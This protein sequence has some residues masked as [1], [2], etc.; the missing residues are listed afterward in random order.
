MLRKLGPWRLMV[1]FCLIFSLGAAGIWGGERA[2]SAIQDRIPVRR[3]H[4]IIID[5]GHGGEDGGATSCTGRL[6]SGY[7]LEIAL[8]L[9]DMLH[10]LGLRTEMIRRTDTSVYRKGE[11]IAQK[12]V[13]DLKNRVRMVNETSG[14][15]LVSIHQNYFSQSQYSGAQVFYGAADGSKDLADSV[16]AALIS[17]LNPDSRR[18]TKAAKGIYLMDKSQRC[19][20][21]VEC[22]FLS[23]PEEAAKLA[24]QDY[25]KALA[26][27]IGAAVCT[28]LG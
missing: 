7:N 28:N 19:A 20:I 9:E 6:E 10:F 3:T 27:V 5:A 12:K 8:R 22:G 2:V 26:A 25:Q 18:R 15:I 13:D 24:S 14:G 21:L 1:C 11:T 4:T 16:Q 23:N 17:T